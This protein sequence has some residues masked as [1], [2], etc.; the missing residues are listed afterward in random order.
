MKAKTYFFRLLIAF[1][2]FLISFGIYAAWSILA[3][4]THQSDIASSKVKLASVVTETHNSND[5]FEAVCCPKQTGNVTVTVKKFISKEGDKCYRYTTKNDTNLAIQG[6]DI[7]LD[8]TT[9]SSQLSTFPKGWSVNKFNGGTTES[10]NSVS[11]VEAYTEEESDKIYISP[12]SFWVEPGKSSSFH[13]CMQNDWD[14]TYETASW[15]IYKYDGSYGY[16]KGKLIS[17]ILSK[18]Y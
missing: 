5:E 4:N 18:V 3:A 15:K 6:I 17:K 12:K 14:S 1:L 13:V 11:M 9:D 7:G 2:T 8:S 16:I 10:P